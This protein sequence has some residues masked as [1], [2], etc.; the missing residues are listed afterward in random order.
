MRIYCDPR[1][2][3]MNQQTARTP[4]HHFHL[5]PLTRPFSTG[6]QAD[7]AEAEHPTQLPHVRQPPKRE[8]ETKL[9]E[10]EPLL[11]PTGLKGEPSSISQRGAREGS[12]WRAGWL[13]IIFARRSPHALCYRL[14]ALQL[15]P[16]HMTSLGVATEMS[17]RSS[18][19]R[20]TGAGGWAARGRG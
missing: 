16:W 2:H 6:S 7:R 18:A 8:G 19:S 12:A 13:C 20:T 9:Q 17:A 15:G 10:N 4:T 3:W 1:H 14:G 5:K 11:Y